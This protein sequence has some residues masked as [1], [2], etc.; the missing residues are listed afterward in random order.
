[1]SN[2][3]AGPRTRSGRLRQDPR[4]Q[5]NER[6]QNYFGSTKPVLK[7]NCRKTV[8]TPHAQRW[9]CTFLLQDVPMGE[10][11]E[12]LNQKTAKKEAAQKALRWME[13][14]GYP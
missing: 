10:S 14:K 5:L 8:I 1:M 7:V 12:A 6:V 11:E 4:Q 9:K 13:E 3:A 2:P